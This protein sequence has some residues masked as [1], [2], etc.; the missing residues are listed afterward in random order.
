MFYY[1]RTIRKMEVVQVSLASREALLAR[2]FPVAPIPPPVCWL[3]RARLWSPSPSVHAEHSRLSTPGVI[4]AHSLLR[5]SWYLMLQPAELLSKYRQ[6]RTEKE[7]SQLL[8]GALC[9]FQ[10]RAVIFGLSSTS[11]YLL[12]YLSRGLTSRLVLGNH[13][14]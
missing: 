14:T 12:R 10:N 2:L 1:I 6:A 9:S 13:S 5:S 7:A 11:V 3:F 4:W 8:K